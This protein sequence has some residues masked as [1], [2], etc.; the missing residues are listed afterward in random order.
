MIK[1]KGCTEKAMLAF[2]S[3]P[4]FFLLRQENNEMLFPL[5]DGNIGVDGQ[6]VVVFFCPS[7]KTVG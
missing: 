4:S 6:N 7:I 5:S 3:H 2:S 1:D